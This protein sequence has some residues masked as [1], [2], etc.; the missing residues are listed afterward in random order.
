M[1]AL[2]V[3]GNIAKQ[4]RTKTTLVNSVRVQSLPFVC[5]VRAGDGDG[6][7][8]QASF[9]ALSGYK[10]PS[11]MNRLIFLFVEW[12]AN[13]APEV[14]IRFDCK[15]S[16]GGDGVGDRQRLQSLLVTAKVSTRSACACNGPLFGVCTRH[17]L[18]QLSWTTC[19]KV[20]VPR[21]GERVD[22]ALG[23]MNVVRGKIDHR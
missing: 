8:V 1:P 10:A 12:Q 11:A 9:A 20:V 2:I 21:E 18:E 16:G 6:N 5:F 7:T 14:G 13:Q 4:F 23:I 15:R 17:R 3:A 19:W 22:E